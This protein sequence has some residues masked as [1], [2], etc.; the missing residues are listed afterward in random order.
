MYSDTLMDHKITQMLRTEYPVDHF[1][2]LVAYLVNLR[3]QDGE[4]EAQG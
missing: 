2:P 1:Q 4:Q 3:A